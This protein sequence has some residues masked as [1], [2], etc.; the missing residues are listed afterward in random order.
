MKKFSTKTWLFGILVLIAALL[1]FDLYL[2]NHTKSFLMEEIRQDFRKK[3]SIS[4]VLLGTNSLQDLDRD[5]L[6]HLVREIKKLTSYRATFIDKDGWVLA[7]SDVPSTELSSVENHLTRPEVQQA[8]RMGHGLDRRKSTT[9]Q[10]KLFYYCEPLRENGRITGFIR[11]AMFSPEYSSRLKF[12]TGLIVQS[13]LFFI[14]ISLLAT[15]F[16]NRMLGSQ[17]THFRKFLSAQRDEAGFQKLPRQPFQEFDLLANEINHLGE[18]LHNFSTDLDSRLQQLLAIFN[19]LSEG[20]AA[21]DRD[22]MVIFHNN[23]FREILGLPLE[24]SR[25]IKFYD[26]IDFPPIIQDIENFLEN[27]QPIKKRIKFYGDRFIDYQILPLLN[28]R[29]SLAGFLLTLADVTHLQ[30]LETIRQDFVANVSHEFKTPLTSIRGYAETLLESGGEKKKQR[31]KF[32]KKIEKQTIHLENLVIDLLQLSRI[33]R[34][35]MEELIKMNPVP[36]IKKL[37]SEYLPMVSERNL[38]LHWEIPKFEKKIRIKANPQILQTILSN[39]INNAIQ[40]NKP[41]GQI[42]FR[43]SVKDTILRMEVEDNGIGIPADQLERIFERFYRVESARYIFPEGS[44]LGL[45]IVKHSVE[46]LSGQIGV[47]S[48]EEQGS[49]FWVEIPLL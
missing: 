42:W 13:N 23:K 3:T 25:K 5:T 10:E 33:E 35:E 41:G 7:D 32:L 22:G 37:L 9:I 28:H 18:K 21:F 17:M 16:Y 24:T 31:E 34:K 29:S 36:V 30:Q 6:Y 26:W 15:F 20:V 19:S 46:L 43:L 45:S 27:H 40:Y 1:V 47:E 39:L 48:K 11:L 4:K 38:I 49:L 14:F 2:W 8:L 12:L 44:G